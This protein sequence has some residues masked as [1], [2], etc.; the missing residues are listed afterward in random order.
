MAQ[1]RAQLLQQ[2]L[3]LLAIWALSVAGFAVAIY[4]FRGLMPRQPAACAVSER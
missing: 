2:L 1:K 3:W 4:G